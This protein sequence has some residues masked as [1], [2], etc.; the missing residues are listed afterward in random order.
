MF[1]L[2]ACLAFSPLSSL[3]L[4]AVNTVHKSFYK[5][6]WVPAVITEDAVSPCS[7]PVAWFL[8]DALLYDFGAKAYFFIIGIFPPNDR[9]ILCSIHL[10]HDSN[11]CT[12]PGCYFIVEG[13]F[14]RILNADS[15]YG[16]H[17]VL[18][19]TAQ[20]S[21]QISSDK[22]SPGMW[23]DLTDGD[24]WIH[25]CSRAEA[26]FAASD[27]PVECDGSIFPRINPCASDQR[28]QPLSITCHRIMHV[29]KTCKM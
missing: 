2:G 16:M 29:W 27:R 19:E 10:Q 12:Q 23:G 3:S 6:F 4:K 17:G 1:S 20:H 18:K 14:Y 13:W 24:E 22:G 15:R 7:P 28:W 25:L 5:L 11:V 26:P 21:S 8:M 9:H